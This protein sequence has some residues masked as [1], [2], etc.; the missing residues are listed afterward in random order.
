M[1]QLTGVKEVD[2]I[3]YDYVYGSR[4]IRNKPNPTYNKLVHAFENQI[5]CYRHVAGRC[6]GF[7]KGFPEKIDEYMHKIAWNDI[8]DTDGYSDEDS[9]DIIYL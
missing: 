6:K 2:E 7:Y 9:D 3:I 4:D 1:R 8:W 5:Y